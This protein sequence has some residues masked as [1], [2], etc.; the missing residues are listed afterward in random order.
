MHPELVR[1]LLAKTA[2]AFPLLEYLFLAQ[3][4]PRPKT[5]EPLEVLE[6]LLLADLGPEEEEGMRRLRLGGGGWGVASL[7]F[8]LAL[9]RTRLR[10]WQ[11][12]PRGLHSG[13]A[14]QAVPHLQSHLAAVAPLR[15]C[16]E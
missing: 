8:R 3:S 7:V 2:R 1:T 13:H 16:L 6:R 14:I 5:T 4:L 12:K 11:A 10:D 15:Q 9:A